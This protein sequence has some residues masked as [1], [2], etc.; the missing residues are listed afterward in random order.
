MQQSETY[1]MSEDNILFFNNPQKAEEKLR[2]FLKAD[3]NQANNLSAILLI[4]INENN[5]KLLYEYLYSEIEL[6]YGFLK[7]AEKIKMN[8]TK[9][10]EFL[11]SD[12][13]PDLQTL[14]KILIGL[15]LSLAI[16]HN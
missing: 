2:K 15:K 13:Q 9:L 1:I 6:S 4:C 10:R 5:F 14:S 8:P 16:V 3:E 11:I 7:F 12:K